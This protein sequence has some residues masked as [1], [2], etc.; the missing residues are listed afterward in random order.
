MGKGKL[1]AGVGF[2]DLEVK[3]IESVRGYYIGT[4]NSLSSISRESV[5]YWDNRSD[6]ENALYRDAWT[7]RE[8]A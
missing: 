7:Q 3:V 8:H 2:P 5:E 1:A 4:A 6:A